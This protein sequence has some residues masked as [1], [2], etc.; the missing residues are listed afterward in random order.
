MKTLW[1]YFGFA[2]ACDETEPVA[3]C[4]TWARVFNVSNQCPAAVAFTKEKAWV[5]ADI[6]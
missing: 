5:L 6:A 1:P 2:V 3:A 4:P